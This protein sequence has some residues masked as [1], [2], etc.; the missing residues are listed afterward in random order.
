[1]PGLAANPGRFH[2]REPERREY[3]GGINHLDE[4]IDGLRG[5][6]YSFGTFKEL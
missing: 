2:I 3:G 5:R 6:G 1:L 4:I